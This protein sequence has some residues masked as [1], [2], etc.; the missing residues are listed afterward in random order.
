MCTGELTTLKRAVRPYTAKLLPPADP[1][2]GAPG[3]GDQWPEK[4]LVYDYVLGYKFSL[5]EP[6]EASV[7]FP[8]LNC[9]LYD[10]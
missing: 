4:R 2:E 9:Q 10:R 7:R 1:L 8:S 3:F 6:I 5:K